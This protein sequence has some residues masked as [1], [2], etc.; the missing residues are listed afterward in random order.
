MVKLKMAHGIPAFIRRHTK[1]A[2]L[3]S[4]AKSLQT[5]PNLFGIYVNMRLHGPKQHFKRNFVTNITIEMMGAKYIQNK[6]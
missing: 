4:L 5:E 2:L 3:L 1:S 6:N